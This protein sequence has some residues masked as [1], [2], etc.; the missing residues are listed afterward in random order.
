MWTPQEQHRAPAFH[1][2]LQEL[3]SIFALGKCTEC[4]A[5]LRAFDT[6]WQTH[7]VGFK[8]QQVSAFHT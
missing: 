3:H 8:H 2:M 5:L 7:Y 6:Q 1:V 4:T